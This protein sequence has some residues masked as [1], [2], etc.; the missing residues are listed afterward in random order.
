MANTSSSTINLGLA[1]I[2]E[3]QE[4]KSFYEFVKVYN[5]IKILAQ[6]IDTYTSDGTLKD[7]LSE[8]SDQIEGV[9]DNTAELTELKK[10]YFSYTLPKLTV[11]GEFACNGKPASTAVTITSSSGTAPAGGTGTAAGG[12]DTAGHRDAA[13]TAIN[14]NA[15]AITEIQNILKTFGL[16]T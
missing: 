3:I 7:T 6:F 2:P 13:I 4:P 8:L 16:A 5:A 9:V 12:W 15:A 1:A 11:V 14:N 10:K